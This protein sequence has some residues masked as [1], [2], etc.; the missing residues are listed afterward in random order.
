M[1]IKNLLTFAL[2]ATMVAAAPVDQESEIMKRT[3]GKF[4]KDIL[5]AHNFF[6]KQH[7]APEIKWDQTLADFGQGVTNTCNFKHSVRTSLS[8][9]LLPPLSRAIAR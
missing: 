5:D 3:D 1:Q 2:G 6:R 8:S 9:P 4:I 7:G